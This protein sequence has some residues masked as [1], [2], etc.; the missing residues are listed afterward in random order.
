[1]GDASRVI[2]GS[3]VSEGVFDH[4][5]KLLTSR[6]ENLRRL[7]TAHLDT[8]FGSSPMNAHSAH[9]LN[10][11]LETVESAVNSIGVLNISMAQFGEHAFVYALV[12]RLSPRLRGW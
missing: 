2:S 10:E 4:A 3:T 1:M 5:W 11:V 6:Y 7:V 9:E 8:L 12:R